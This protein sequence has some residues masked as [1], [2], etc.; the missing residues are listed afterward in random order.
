MLI[1]FRAF[2]SSCEEQ[3]CAQVCNQSSFVI[4]V[5]QFVSKISAV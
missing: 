2:L 5:L 1:T 4:N 3:V